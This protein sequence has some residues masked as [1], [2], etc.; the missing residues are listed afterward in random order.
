MKP[1]GHP[2]GTIVAAAEEIRSGK[3]AIVGGVWFALALLLGASKILSRAPVPVIPAILWT[4]VAIIL[5]AFWWS[6]SFRARATSIDMRS[7]VAVHLTR[8]VGI[9]FLVL[10]DRG[11]LPWA[12]AVPGGWGDIAVAVAAFAVFALV[13]PRGKAAWQVYLLWNMLG[14]AD[15]LLVVATAARLALADRDSMIAITH[16]PLSL[17]P[18]FLVPIIISTHVIMLVRLRAARRRGSD[19]F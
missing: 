8:F 17:L 10:H 15:I 12:F 2:G 18:T 5:L 3:I 9:Y 7:L 6:A 14:L 19:T 16:L 1:P 4:L 13:P 11:L